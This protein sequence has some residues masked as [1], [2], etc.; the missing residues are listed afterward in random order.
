ME[1]VWK[2]IKIEKNGIIYDYIGLYQISNKGRVKSLNY[3]RS[4]KEGIIKPRKCSG[5]FMVKLAK[6]GTKEDFLVHRLVAS[7][8]IPNPNCLP[9][10]NHKDEDKENNNVDNLEWCDDTYNNTYGTFRERQASKMK[11]KMIGEAHPLYGKHHSDETKHKISE[12]KKGKNKGEN[13]N[14]SRKIVCIETEQV[15]DTI[16][17]AEN[18]CNCTSIKQHLANRCKSAGKHPITKERLHWMY[19][20][21]WLAKR[22]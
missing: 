19:Y 13:N 16:T 14:K 2:D 9:L 20:E 22:K 10:I 15:F 7:A 18:W 12:S 8:F 4:G 21:E 3:C 5:Y 11:G 6:N 1:E 17:E